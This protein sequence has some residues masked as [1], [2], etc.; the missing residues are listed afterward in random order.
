MHTFQLYVIALSFFLMGCTSENSIS[1][2]TS[3]PKPESE[4]LFTLY[5]LDGDRYPGDPVPDG[6][7]LLHGWQI[8]KTCSIQDSA[9]RKKIFN[10]FDAGI[11][12]IGKPSSELQIDCF[13]PRHAIRV[14]TDDIIVDYLICFQCRNYDIW[15]GDTKVSGGNIASSPRATF[16][17]ILDNCK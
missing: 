17:R 6:A 2:Q 13:N 9:T 8:L 16:N 14:E 4:A 15:E 10:A 3:A 11:A 12:E 7:K 1:N 5:S